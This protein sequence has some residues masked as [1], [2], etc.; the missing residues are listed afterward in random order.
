[1]KLCNFQIRTEPVYVGVNDFM[2]DASDYNFKA[3]HVGIHPDLLCKINF[4]NI[5][6]TFYNKIQSMDLLDA[7]IEGLDAPAGE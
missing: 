4:Q 7:I 3:S 2:Y 5:I 6:D 1:V